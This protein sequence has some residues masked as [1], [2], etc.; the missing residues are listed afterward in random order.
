MTRERNPDAYLSSLS[1]LTKSC[2][3]DLKEF[4]Q[5]KSAA[6]MAKGSLLRSVILQFC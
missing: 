5:E 2:L 6:G 4:E 3:D 1:D